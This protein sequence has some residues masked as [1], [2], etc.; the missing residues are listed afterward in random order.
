VPSLSDADAQ[1]ELKDAVRIAIEKGFARDSSAELEIRNL[2]RGN[3][4]VGLGLMAEGMRK[5]PSE[6]M[7]MLLSPAVIRRIAGALR[8]E[9]PYYSCSLCPKKTRKGQRATDNPGGV[10][11]ARV[12]EKDGIVKHLCSERHYRELCTRGSQTT[13]EPSVWETPRHLEFVRSVVETVGSVHKVPTEG[14]MRAWFE[15]FPRNL[16]PLVAAVGSRDVRRHSCCVGLGQ[17]PISVTD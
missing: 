11:D 4:A 2:Q 1:A 5:S 15:G 10:A 13:I 17:G 16:Y 6:V 7:R 8:T 9:L 14:G 12:F 3:V